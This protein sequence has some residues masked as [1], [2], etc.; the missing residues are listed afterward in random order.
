M[1]AILAL[2]ARHRTVALRVAL[3][4]AAA[5]VGG[6]AVHRLDAAPLARARARAEA[7]AAQARADA[8]LAQTRIDTAAAAAVETARAAEAHAAARTG[9][10]SDAI[11]RLPH[12]ADPV[13]RDVLAEWGRAVDGLRD[14]AARARPA[15][16]P[17]GGADAARSVPPA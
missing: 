5:A 1:I 4:L 3:A 9:A 15:A 6:W 17:A 16:D 14:E 12:A 13:D 11:A 10:A 7:A 8:A 2:L